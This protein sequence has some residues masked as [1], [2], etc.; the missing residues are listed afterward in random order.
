MQSWPDRINDIETLIVSGDHMKC[1]KLLERINPRQLPREWA[2]RVAQAALRIQHSILALKILHG[3]VYPKNQFDQPA[4]DLE[5]SIYANSLNRLGATSEA[6][7][8]LSGLDE[9]LNPEVL[10]YRGIAHFRQWNYSEGV[11]AFRQYVAREDLEPYRRIV[12]QVNLAAGL[13]YLRQW[14]EGLELIEK[15]KTKCVEG[16]YQLLLGN[17][18]ELEAQ[19]YFFNKQYDQALKLLEQSM[20]MLKNENGVYLHYVQKW[21]QFCHC[22]LDNA[23][24]VSKKFEDLRSISLKNGYWETV[25]EC[26]LFE[27]ILTQDEELLRKVIIGTPCDSYRLRARTLFGKAVKATGNYQLLLLP[28]E[29]DRHSNL[30]AHHFDPYETESEANAL[31]TTPLLLATFE[32]LTVDFYKPAY[33]GSLFK[34][35]YPEEKFNPYT[36]PPRILRLLKRLDQWLKAA[37]VPLA[38][39]FK[40]SE[41]QLKASTPILIQIRRGPRLTS[42]AGKL[43]ELYKA[44]PGRSFSS[45]SAA[46]QM[47][48]SVSSAQ[49][50]IKQAL[51]DGILI[52]CG[53]GRGSLYRFAPRNKRRSAA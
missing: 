52:S 18:L 28:P 42:S 27:A 47:G 50:L 53:R 21:V 17:C 2:T 32:A 23:P 16:D 43:S 14:Q 31:H 13:I 45:S 29:G 39:Q 26:D 9:T 3:F 25:R 1:R 10:F 6:L 22:F 48:V 12:G 49:K 11:R 19:I 15:I 40:K 37:S 5:K 24:D 30:R 20:T 38:V 46:T 33:I 35:I 8:I 7:E 34:F 44:F 4:T 51:A 41:F 36:S